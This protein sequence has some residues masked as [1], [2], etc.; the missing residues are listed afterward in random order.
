M[1]PELNEL[2]QLA[3]GTLDEP[4]ASRIRK[5]LT[6]C[7]SC[8]AAYADAVRYRAAWL[9]EEEAFH[10]D[11]SDRR[12]LREALGEGSGAGRRRSRA[13]R[14]GSAL[15]AAAVLAVFAVAVFQA[16]NAAPTLGFRLSPAVL[17]ASAQ[18]SGRGLV[19]PGAEK[20]A[21]RFRPELRAGLPSSSL[22]LDREMKA[23]VESYESGSRGPDDSGRVVAALLAHGEIEAARGYAREGLRK[24]PSAVPLLVF[25]AA[26]DYRANDIGGA[27]ELLRRAAGRAPHDPL[28]ALDLGLVVRREGHEDEARRLLSRVADSRNV[29]LAARARRELTPAP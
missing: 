3:E 26:A 20:H 23:A 29:A 14:L 21:D 16:M 4:D 22:E 1:H 5:H 11:S 15:V 2:A 18:S 28:V 13:L 7:R 19:L 9:A 6:R 8:T 25:G 12:I 24:Y 10:L 17:E 27:E